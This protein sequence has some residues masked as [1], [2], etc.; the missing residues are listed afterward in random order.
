ML[1]SL[2]QSSFRGIMCSDTALKS[3]SGE[4]EDGDELEEIASSGA[5]T[6][7]LAPLRESNVA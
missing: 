6:R 4:D 1:M 5:W 2:L 7:I 3:K